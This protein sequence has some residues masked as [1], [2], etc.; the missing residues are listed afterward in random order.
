AAIGALPVAEVFYGSTAN[1]VDLETVVRQITAKLCAILPTGLFCAAALFDLS[2]ENGTLRAWNG[3]MP[4]LLVRDALG[5]VKQR[6]PSTQPAL[7]IMSAGELD[8]RLAC[9][10]LDPGDRICAYSD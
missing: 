8:A 7:G 9:V 6:V 4:D 1:G 5:R 3:A 10:S 2:L